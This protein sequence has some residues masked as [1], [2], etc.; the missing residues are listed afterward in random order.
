M[1]KHAI[2]ALIGA[3]ALSVAQIA[4]AKP[5]HVAVLP[6]WMDHH[7]H[8]YDY[9]FREAGMTWTNLAATIEQMDWLGERLD[10][11]DLLFGP[12]LFGYKND[13]KTNPK[14]YDM[15]KYVPAIRKWIEKGGCLFIVDANYPE[16]L[17]WIK[18]IDPSLEVSTGSCNIGP[19]I[20]VEPQDSIL[21]FPKRA[22]YGF[23]W[24]HMTVPD[25]KKTGWKI[26]SRC[27]HG[28][29]TL[30][31][32]RMG[33]G[34]ILITSLRSNVPEFVENLRVNQQFLVLGLE[35]QDCVVPDP[36]PGTNTF[37]VTCRN[38]SDRKMKGKLEL[39][40]TP[41]KKDEEGKLVPA[42]SAETYRQRTT[43]GA[44]T[45]GIYRLDCRISERG[46][47]RAR[48]VLEAGGTSGTCFD[49]DMTLAPLFEVTGPRYRG[50]V[51]VDRRFDAIKL[52]TRIF[53]NKEDLGALSVRI[54]I[55]NKDKRVL[56]KG[57]AAARRGET[58]IDVPFSKQTKPGTYDVIGELV[59]TKSGKVLATDTDT[60]QVVESTPGL[61]VF[62]EDRMM[63]HD[64]K[65][66]F[67]LG[68][69]HPNGSKSYT[70][71]FPILADLGFNTIQTFS[72]AGT[73]HIDLIHKVGATVL[74]ELLPHRTP[75]L[76][77]AQAANMETHPAPL[78]YYTMD[79]PPAA[80]F[81][82]V[83][84]L[85]KAYREND[86]GRPT[87]LVSYKPYEFHRNAWLS[88]VLA[89]DPYPWSTKRGDESNI[90]MVSSWLDRAHEASDSTRP[91]IC[92]PQAF[93]AEPPDIWR[94][95]GIQA[96]THGAAGL[97]WY[98]W[99]EGNG[100][101]LAHNKKL[102][103]TVCAFLA[104]IKSI[105]PAILNHE[106]LP[107]RF[108][109]ADYK[110]HA[111][112][113]RDPETKTR[114]LLVANSSKEP[115][116]VNVELMGIPA[117][118][119][120]IEDAFGDRTIA[121]SNGVAE[122]RLG[123]FESGVFCWDGPKPVLERP[124]TDFA[125]RKLPARSSGKKLT[126]V[127]PGGAIPAN[128]YTNLQMA[129]D[130]AK[131]G[132]VILVGE[133]TYGPIVCDNLLV[134]I[135]ATG[136]QTNTF[137][138]ARGKGRCAALTQ[139][140]F[141]D[142]SFQTNTLLRGFTLRN[143]DSRRD[144]FRD[145]LGG[146]VIGGT[147]EG[148]VIE[149]SKA[150]YGGGAAYS[151]LSNCTFRANT[152]TK[153]GGAAMQSTLFDSL[154]TG[155]SADYDGGA[156]EFST[157]IRCTLRDNR[158]RRDGG[159]SHYGRNVSCHIRNNSANRH[160]GA[161]AYSAN[162]HS[163]IRSNRTWGGNGG[164]VF[165]GETTFCTIAGNTAANFGGGIAGLELDGA[166]AS[167]FVHESIIWGN[168]SNKD[169]GATRS[170]FNMVPG[171]GCWMTSA[172]SNKP[173]RNVQ[174]NNPCFMVE[175][176]GD[177]R[178]RP[179]SPCRDLSGVFVDRS[180]VDPN[181]MARPTG[182][183][184]DAGCFE[185]V[186]DDLTLLDWHFADSSDFPSTGMNAI[187]NNTPKTTPRIEKDALVFK[188]DLAL[189]SRYTL[190]N[191]GATLRHWSAMVVEAEFK[192]Q[193]KGTPA[194]ALSHAKDQG[195]WVESNPTSGALRLIV[196][197][198]DP[199]QDNRF[200][201]ESKAAVTDGK[202][203]RI[204]FQIDRFGG[205]DAFLKVKLDGADLPCVR[206]GKFSSWSKLYNL[207]GTNLKLG[208]RENARFRG[209]FKSLRLSVHADPKW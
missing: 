117:G 144:S 178:L 198:G 63:M 46:L 24:G 160:G 65:P 99:N 125:V 167:R 209:E 101:G 25:Q 194:L 55:E 62:D 150:V 184:P 95:M 36:V 17:A 154:V 77:A 131:D 129:I 181:G 191:M 68:I 127:A 201:F 45:N 80:A 176:W 204:A 60:V 173:P 72:W 3:L 185:I 75:C 183:G 169:K 66:F 208:W 92:V 202:W 102:Q 33:R 166:G 118:L 105:T 126:V 34:I 49:R 170:Y 97:I 172:V 69:Y 133:G 196:A 200:V 151:I 51:A 76:A 182:G 30:M 35:V 120:K 5:Y 20:G 159:A 21:F 79:E 174:T 6:S 175:S 203:H 135:I 56:G 143:G 48:L 142:M 27:G 158:A 14:A 84:E 15:K 9:A 26:L 148:C 188:G 152:A 83:H 155:N 138:D 85:D 113:C 29:P 130:V 165:N 139:K 43:I 149:R 94:N 16:P 199:K 116:S 108:T 186:S 87:Y 145:T 10:D 50:L 2:P 179:D 90:A 192:T 104:E 193:Q 1:K 12:C 107:H 137:I 71:D 206:K 40:L 22:E 32:K 13:P 132:D 111:M 31:I 128:A 93:G 53:P 82:L 114:Y 81:D 124:A 146:G 8:E 78:L 58:W 177:Y 64:G 163:L 70:S 157:A 67:P 19:A 54:R 47:Y 4:M 42:G 11:F 141:G 52:G 162:A 136:A 38:L 123:R 121:I 171:R 89:P 44:N 187:R 109:A 73:K 122:I 147:L 28:D 207:P 106:E 115:L 119:T 197:I 18:E 140:P 156:L 134:D 168:Y 37:T 180:T 74:W 41:L 23:T 59:E 98:A 61:T 153:N 100:V 164:G 39:S 91:V 112:T 161:T 103:E 57:E 88:D 110:L 205:L 195:I 7:L 86:P 189:S 190:G 96:I